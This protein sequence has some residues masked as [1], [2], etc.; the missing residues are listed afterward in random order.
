MNNSQTDKMGS[1]QPGGARRSL[2]VLPPCRVGCCVPYI[3]FFHLSQQHWTVTHLSKRRKN[4]T[5]VSQPTFYDNW[6]SRCYGRQVKSIYTSSCILQTTAES[7]NETT[8]TLSLINQVSPLQVTDL[9]GR[10][11]PNMGIR[12]AQGSLL[13]LL[14]PPP[15]MAMG[16]G[17]FEF[18]GA[19]SSKSN[20]AMA[21]QRGVLGKMYHDGSRL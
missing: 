14:P 3:G 19:K 1:Y 11:G 2:G 5:H 15:S 21:F 12:K 20:H 13:A 8:R 16:K 18:Q 17:S 4:S 6:K 9:K 7:Q 10:L